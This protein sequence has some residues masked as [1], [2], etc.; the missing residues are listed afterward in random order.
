[1]KSKHTHDM[2][3]IHKCITSFPENRSPNPMQP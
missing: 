2:Y 3:I 1:M